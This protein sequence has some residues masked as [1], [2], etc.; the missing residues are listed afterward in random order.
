MHENRRL[1]LAKKVMEELDE[2][3][4]QRNRAFENDDLD[5]AREKLKRD[6]CDEVVTM[7][8][9]KARLHCTAITDTARIRS[10]DWLAERELTD[11]YGQPITKD[12][13]L[14]E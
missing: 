11:G 4:A 13:P 10:R 8:F 9:H 3:I 1:I 12:T 7:A 14:P 2:Y 5:W 6:T